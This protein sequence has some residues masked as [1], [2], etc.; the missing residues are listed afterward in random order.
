MSKMRKI[1]CLLM[2]ILFVLASLAGCNGGA[3]N[4][5]PDVTSPP[6]PVSTEEA[7]PVPEAPLQYSQGASDDEIIIGTTYPISG[8]TAFFGVPI[9]DTI[10]ACVDRVNAQGGIGGRTVVLKHYDDGYDA[11]TG[12]TLTEKLVEEDKVFALV[13]MG[14]NIVASSL[15][16]LKD[17]GIP[18]VNITSGLPVVYEENNPTSAIFPVQP[19]AATDGKILLARMLHEPI[20][21]PNKNEK[22]PADTKIAVFHGTDELGLN[23]AEN[24]QAQAELE[25]AAARL[26]IE[27]VGTA[28]TYA[29][30]I[31]KAKTEGAGAVIFCGTDSK[32][33]I[34][35]M[36]DAG[37]EVPWLGFYGTSTIQSFAPETYK[38][39]RPCY[40]SNWADYTTPESQVMLDDLNDALT[41]NKDLDAATLESY[42]D[43][44]YC[45]GGYA[46]IAT[47]LEGLKRLDEN[48]VDFTWENFIKAMEQAPFELGGI[49]YFN[50]A[51][52]E[53]MGVTKMSLVEYVV[54]DGEGAQNSIRGFESVEDVMQK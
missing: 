19:A 34:A 36:D 46:A 26:I 17:Y 53:R 49:G 54:I 31:Q 13:C 11:A 27:T 39:G 12:K 20:F 16:Y 7:T 5:T 48:N 35:A 1:S 15:D 41:Y 18:V 32:T 44:N 38:P 30:A 43:N 14:G 42:K 45:R 25:G 40:S 22:L 2:A 23:L 33:F 6:A 4:A 52:G 28:E 10:K 9:M 51:G 47:L 21:G 50:Y 24:I 8:W 3:A 29:T 37:W